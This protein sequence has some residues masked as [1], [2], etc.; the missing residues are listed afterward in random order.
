MNSLHFWLAITGNNQHNSNFKQ[1]CAGCE[2]ITDLKL[3]WK[4]NFSIMDFISGKGV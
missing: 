1:Q 4:L 2:M 3:H